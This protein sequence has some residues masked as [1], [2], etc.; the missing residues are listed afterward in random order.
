MVHVV[1]SAL[2]WK[3]RCI[4]DASSGDDK[5]VPPNVSRQEPTETNPSSDDTSST[6]TATPP[7]MSTGFSKLG[8]TKAQSNPPPASQSS[9]ETEGSPHRRHCCWGLLLGSHR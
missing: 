9:T 5:N 1:H 4:Q 3:L 2:Y 8:Y 6:G 7:W